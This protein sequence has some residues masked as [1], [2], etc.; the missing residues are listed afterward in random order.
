MLDKIVPTVTPFQGNKINTTLLK[1][2]VEQ[3]LSDGVDMVLLCG[4]TG[5]GP[6][7]SFQERADA[8]R[9]LRDHADKII[10]HVGSLNFFET[11]ELARIG[12]NFGVKY[13]ASL[14]PYYF[15]RIRDDWV[16]REL[17]EISKIHPTILYNYP[18]ATGYDATSAIAKRIVELGGNL[19]GVKDTINEIPHMLAYKWDLGSDFKVYTGPEAV[20][21]AAVRTGMDGSVAGAGNYA[22]ELFVKL[23]R[24]PESTEALDR[25][26]LLSEL[27]AISRKYGQWAANYVMTRIMRG[28]DVG[29]PRAPIF[30]VSSEESAKMEQEVRAI[31][32]FPKNLKLVDHFRRFKH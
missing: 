14:P 32:N 26:R 31:L 15:P 23:L 12:K 13:L 19:V 6:S 11:L 4:T 8:L 18:L 1:H 3:M 27:A 2:H 7:L 24:E 16:V 17:A 20:I 25:Q 30:P 21:L 22:T 10:F 5:L 28:Y 9:S 29:E